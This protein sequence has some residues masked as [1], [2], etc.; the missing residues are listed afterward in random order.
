MS[1]DQTKTERRDDRRETQKQG[2]RFYDAFANFSE[3]TR[4]TDHTFDGFSDYSAPVTRA[5]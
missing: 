2:D 4:L 5:T 3:Q 1:S